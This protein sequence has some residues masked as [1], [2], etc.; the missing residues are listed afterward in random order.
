M[1]IRLRWPDCHLLTPDGAPE[2][3]YFLECSGPEAQAL[4]GQVHDLHLNQNPAWPRCFLASADGQR[5]QAVD[6]VLPYSGMWNDSN[7]FEAVQAVHITT[8][9]QLPQLQL[10]P[11]H[12]EWP[13]ELL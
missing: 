7:P 3:A 2:P 1:L 11:D 9:T 10:T 13:A 5:V 8:L 12:W 6:R 4:T